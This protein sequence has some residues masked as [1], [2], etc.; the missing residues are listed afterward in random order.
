MMMEAQGFF[1]LLSIPRLTD[2]LKSEDID[3]DHKRKLGLSFPFFHYLGTRDTHFD[4]I[5][6]TVNS[7]GREII[8]FS[9]AQLHS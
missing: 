9:Q 3:I 5:N 4:A 6:S 2:S 1:F 8:P 7:Q